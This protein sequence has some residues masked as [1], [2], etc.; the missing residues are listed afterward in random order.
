MVASSFGAV[1]PLS[2]GAAIYKISLGTLW[3]LI[4]GCRG[5][6]PTLK[7]GWASAGPGGGFGGPSLNHGLDHGT[8]RTM[9]LP[10]KI[11]ALRGDAQ[12]SHRRDGDYRR[13]CAVTT[14]ITTQARIHCRTPPISSAG[15]KSI[16]FVLLL[17]SGFC[18][19][20]RI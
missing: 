10:G 1:P 17:S 4:R 7:S 2:A 13:S 11:R 9:G 5:A 19:A 20:G 8:R 3:G 15:L 14:Y 12:R 16:V 18:A 6:P